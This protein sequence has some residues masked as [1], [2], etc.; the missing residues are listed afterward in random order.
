MDR[1]APERSE[2]FMVPPRLEYWMVIL[3]LKSVA[4]VKRTRLA[5][6]LFV[7]VITDRV[8]SDIEIFSLNFIRTRFFFF[9][10]F[11]TKFRNEIFLFSTKNAI[12]RKNLTKWYRES[13]L[14][15]HIRRFEANSCILVNIIR[16]STQPATF[17]RPLIHR[18]CVNCWR[19]STETLIESWLPFRCFITR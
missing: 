12:F 10:F 3:N 17:P 13:F 2:K 11:F 18:P 1:V 14:W 8:Y 7:D 6:N 5:A 9:L 4:S 19:I 15:P 16:V